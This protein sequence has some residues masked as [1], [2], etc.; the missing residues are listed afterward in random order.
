M[1]KVAVLG[2][3]GSI[4]TQTL[5]VIRNHKDELCVHS[6]VAYSNLQGLEK[7]NREFSPKYSGLI[8]V[9]GEE[10]LLNAVRG[11]DVCVVAT[12]GIVALQ[13]VLYCLD[14]G[15]DVALANKEVLVCAG[16][17][18]MP[19]VGKAKL[20]PV[21]SEHCAISQCLLGK[22]RGDV[23]K[24]L[25]TASGGPFF[26]KDKNCFA[27]FTAQDAL[28]HPNWSMGS[29]ITIDSATMFNKALEVV[30]ASH[31]FGVEAQD[32]QIVVHRQSVV[33]SMVQFVDGSVLCQMASPDM[34]LPIQTALLHCCKPSNVQQLDFEQLMTLT[35]QKC[36][37]EK[38]PCAKLGYEIFNYPP[39]CATVMNASNDVCV[40]SF[41]QGILP[42]DAFYDV[43]KTAV[44]HFADTA[45][46]VAVTIETI[47]E[48]DGLAKQFTKQLIWE[49]Y[50]K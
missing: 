39:I 19:K 27:S 50:G 14:N 18:V 41:L 34:R 1:K 33:H 46:N 20:L 11:A 17:I 10:C 15:I 45:Q 6:L 2:C 8:S 49:R 32:I 43:I 42:F 7:L 37:F 24:L 5:D 9:D 29:K 38:F 25:L 40:E 4:G 48:F 13:A 28:K 12:R 22:N 35:F 31:L 3:T 30:E 23:C 21:D 47:K 26:E 16:C 44:L 36:D